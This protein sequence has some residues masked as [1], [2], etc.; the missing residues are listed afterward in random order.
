MKLS[1]GPEL[2]DTQNNADRKKKKRKKDE[3]E[4]NAANEPYRHN[5]KHTPNTC[6]LALKLTLRKA[7]S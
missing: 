1:F 4:G 5:N 3:E 7:Y 2:P 6:K